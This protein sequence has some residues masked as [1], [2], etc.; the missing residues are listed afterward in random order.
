MCFGRFGKLQ[1]MLM[2]INFTEVYLVMIESQLMELSRCIIIVT[3]IVTIVYVTGSRWPFSFDAIV[4]LNK[5]HLNYR[6]IG[7]HITTVSQTSVR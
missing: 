2:L 3:A 1:Q 4:Q 6:R 5:Y 7:R